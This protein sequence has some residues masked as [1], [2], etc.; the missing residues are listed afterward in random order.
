MRCSQ[1]VDERL[2]ATAGDRRKRSS[3]AWGLS[4]A[5]L[6]SVHLNFARGF[7]SIS[8]PALAIEELD[9]A[10]AL[11]PGLAGAHHTKGHALA[12]VGEEAAALESLTAAL[13]YSHGDPEIRSHQA[14]L[15]RRV[16]ASALSQTAPTA[17]STKETEAPAAKKK[18][19]KKKKKAG[20]K[21]DQK[22]K[23]L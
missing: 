9:T 18:S 14:A 13:E 17:Q 8:E 19:R 3:A 15:E 21:T 23:E 6:A 5:K 12:M 1:T 10:L 7:M 4:R 20:G 16:A 11:Q 2:S 22:Q